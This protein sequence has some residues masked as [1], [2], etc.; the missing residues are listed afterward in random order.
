MQLF[1]TIKAVNNGIKDKRQN[2]I[3]ERIMFIIFWDLLMAKQMFLSPQVKWS[4][5][6][7]NKQAYT[8][9][10]TIAKQLKTL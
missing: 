4:I 8:S 6:I 7:S 1:S 2:R 5:I 3:L 9:Y 10:L